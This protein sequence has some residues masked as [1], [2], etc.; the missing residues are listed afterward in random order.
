MRK[1]SS[2]I[3]AKKNNPTAKSKRN[4]GL[5]QFSI[6][7][8]SFRHKCYDSL[9]W[10]V[11]HWSTPH[12][13]ALLCCVFVRFTFD[14]LLRIQ[15]EFSLSVTRAILLSNNVSSASMC[16]MNIEGLR[17]FVRVCVLMK[18]AAI[19]RNRAFLRFVPR[20]SCL[21]T[22][23]NRTGFTSSTIH[24]CSTLRPWINNE[25]NASASSMHEYVCVCVDGAKYYVDIRIQ[26]D[27]HLRAQSEHER[28]RLL[29]VDAHVCAWKRVRTIPLT[30]T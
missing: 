4:C 5:S 13:S 21:R 2:A 6:K 12:W 25:L 8:N 27:P 17:E 29:L 1:H 22:E 15:S 9:A 7:N 18:I 14:N 19:H 3:W 24:K 16:V 11:K 28:V 30:F 23:T 10:P 26:W 20:S